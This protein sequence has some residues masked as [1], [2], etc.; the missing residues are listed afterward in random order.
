MAQKHKNQRELV[1]E[2]A[3]K[4]RFE[5]FKMDVEML[6]L[7]VRKNEA[8]QKLLK[9]AVDSHIDSFQDIE[10]NFMDR[11]PE[12]VPALIEER[13][14]FLKSVGVP[15]DVYVDYLNKEIVARKQQQP[16]NPSDQLHAIKE[17]IDAQTP[18][19]VPV[20]DDVVVEPTVEPE[21]EVTD[22]VPEQPKN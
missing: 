3:P 12:L 22:V 18:K 19:D 21:P 14:L 6:E 2:L 10:I 16:Q 1:R 15:E 7:R 20:E 5:A 4:A 17:Q 11:H 8:Q 9:V 13:N